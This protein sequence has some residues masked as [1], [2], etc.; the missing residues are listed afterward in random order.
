MHFD[1]ACF[2]SYC[3][4]QGSLVQDF[5]HQVKDAL[6]D[7]LG[8]YSGQRVVIDRDLL[9]AGHLYNISL[10]GAICRS[11]C[12]IVIYM[13]AYQNSSYCQRELR[14]MEILQ[15]QRLPMLPGQFGRDRGLIIP[16]ALRG[17]SNL[18]KNIQHIHGADFSSWSLGDTKLR[19][20]KKYNARFRAIAGY[21]AELQQGFEAA[22]GNPCADCGSFELPPA[23]V[24]PPRSAGDLPFSG[25]TA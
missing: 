13:P 23:M 21:I 17:W 22:A 2:I 5:V 6:T 19:I 3:H 9:A 4:A 10:A 1:Y 24:L 25:A 18:P 16:L 20:N 11:V 7:E 12:M 15:A 8:T 14:A